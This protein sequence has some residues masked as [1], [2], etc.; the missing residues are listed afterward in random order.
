[1]ESQLDRLR[2]FIE[3]DTAEPDERNTFFQAFIESTS[4]FMGND[5]WDK[6]RLPL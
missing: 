6:L 5:A 3:T 4:M 1:V 2:Q